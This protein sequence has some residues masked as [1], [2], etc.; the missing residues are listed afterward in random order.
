MSA[1]KAAPS[2]ISDEVRVMAS[3]RPE[4]ELYNLSGRTRRL[5][6]N[7]ADTADKMVKAMDLTGS[8]KFTVID[9]YAGMRHFPLIFSADI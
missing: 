9:M 7:N 6:L 8:E 3:I 1:S 4:H 5:I 2:S